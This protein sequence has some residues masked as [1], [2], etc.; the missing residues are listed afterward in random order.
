MLTS[1][2]KADVIIRITSTNPKEGTVSPSSLTFNSQNWNSKQK[3]T[4][5]GVDDLL[6]DGHQKY[7]INLWPAASTDLDYDGLVPDSVTVTNKDNDVYLGSVTTPT[8]RVQSAI[9]L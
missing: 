1:K 3:V 9:G 8:N 4:V 7:S 6:P 2:P 5:T